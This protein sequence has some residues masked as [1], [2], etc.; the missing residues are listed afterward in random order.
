MGVLLALKHAPRTGLPS[1]RPRPGILST[2]EVAVSIPPELARKVN[3]IMPNRDGTKH[4]VLT[5]QEAMLRLAERDYGM[6]AKRLA[7]ETG[8]PLS[9]VQSWKRALAPAQMA[10]GDFVAVCRVIPDHLTSLCLEPAGK[11]IISDGEGNALLD[12][13]L[14]KASTYTAEHIRRKADGDICH[15]DRAALSEL[16]LEMGSVAIKAGRA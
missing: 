5:Q 2:V 7:A 1:S 16:A 8:I 10:L 3:T 4:D 9:T 11:Q 6:T 12:E 13:L 14:L 15:V